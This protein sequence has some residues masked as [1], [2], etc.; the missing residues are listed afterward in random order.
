MTAILDF[1]TPEALAE[2]TGWSERRIRKVARALGACVVM[3]GRMVL[4]QEDTAIIVKA[5]KPNLTHDDIKKWLSADAA[6]ILL[7]KEAQ[8]WIDSTG[9]VYFVR[10]DRGNVKIGYTTDIDQRLTKFRNAAPDTFS[11]LLMV[12]GTPTLERYFHQKFAAQRIAREWFQL[13][14]PIDEYIGR[15]RRNIRDGR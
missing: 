13:S 3:G 6:E 15:R 10:N 12:S 1:T 11:V 4:L 5:A 8:D 2:A 14:G 7:E 9:H